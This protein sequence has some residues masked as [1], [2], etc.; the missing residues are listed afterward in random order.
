MSLSRVPAISFQ[1]T[2]GCATRKSSD[3]LLTASPMTRSWC[4]TA[5]WVFASAR[6]AALSAVPLNSTARRA[7]FRISSRCA[8]SRSKVWLRALQDSFASNPVCALLDGA[9]G[10]EVDFTPDDDRELLFHGDVIQ[11]A[12]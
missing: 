1:G 8:S 12:R 5:D 9:L 4:S 10:Y 2:A 7:A 6:N 11:Q 3:S